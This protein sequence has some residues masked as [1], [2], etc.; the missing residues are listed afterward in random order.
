MNGPAE[1]ASHPQQTVAMDGRADPKDHFSMQPVVPSSAF[2]LD[3]D[4]DDGNPTPDPSSYA[5]PVAV[6]VGP[7][8]VSACDLAA[9]VSTFLPNVRTFGES[10]SMA[11][12]LPTQPALGTSLDLGPAWDARSPRR[13]SSRPARRGTT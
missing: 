4:Y 2:V 7:G 5:G 9:I 10:T 12:G 1:I 6:L 3:D 13:T 8:R 11:V